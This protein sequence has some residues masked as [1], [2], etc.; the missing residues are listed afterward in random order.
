MYYKLVYNMDLVDYISEK[1]ER[2]IYCDNDNLDT[3]ARSAN[4]VD[5]QK[6]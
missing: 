6:S 5:G 1:G 4:T 2:Y 3:G